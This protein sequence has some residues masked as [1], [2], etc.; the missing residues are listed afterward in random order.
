MINNFKF[1]MKNIISHIVFISMF[2]LW[3]CGGD[4]SQSPNGDSDCDSVNYSTQCKILPDHQ[5]LQFDYC[6]PSNLIGEKFS[7]SNYSGKIILIEM[8]AAW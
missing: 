6:Y 8:S 1:I 2:L 3:S 7:L 5:S 4:D